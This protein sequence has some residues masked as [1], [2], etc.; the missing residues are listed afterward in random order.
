MVLFTIRKGD[1]PKQMKKAN[2]VP[3]N[4]KFGIYFNLLATIVLEDAASD[5]IK[6]SHPKEP[7]D[8]GVSDILTFEPLPDSDGAEDAVEDI[9]EN[10]EAIDV[11]L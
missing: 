2:N 4:V 11:V 10:E 3:E 7:E 9:N 1:L 8:F 5:F 6:D